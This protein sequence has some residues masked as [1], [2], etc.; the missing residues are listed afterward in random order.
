[1]CIKYVYEKRKNCISKQNLRCI[2]RTYKQTVK[3]RGP[4]KHASSA[5][6]NKSR[7]NVLHC[8]ISRRAEMQGMFIRSK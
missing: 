2:F 8:R 5:T 6:Q 3:T 4:T 1:M 7:K